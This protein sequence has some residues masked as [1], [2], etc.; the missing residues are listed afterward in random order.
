[1]DAPDY[2]DP[3]T[4]GLLVCILAG[5]V[6]LTTLA[7]LGLDVVIDTLIQG[8][9]TQAAALERI[10]AVELVRHG[11]NVLLQLTFI[12]NAV[13]FLIWLYRAVGNNLAMGAS[14]QEYTPAWSVGYFFI[15]LANLVLPYFAMREMW[16]TS[17]DLAGASDKVRARPVFVWWALY[18]GSAVILS[19]AAQV[20]GHHVHDLS[21]LVVAHRM[22]I[23]GF[24]VRLA[25]IAMFMR[26][27]WTATRLQRVPV[28]APRSDAPVR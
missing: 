7:V 6:G 4:L 11:A 14:G 2:E 18:L 27:V 5:V 25:G 17:H 15:P 22:E 1:M 3:R 16:L 21:R 19:I 20:H 10:H 26:I 9:T 13:L 28:A 12:L 24:A 8:T 23:V